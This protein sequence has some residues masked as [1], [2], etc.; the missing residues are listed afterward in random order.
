MTTT[1]PTAIGLPVSDADPFSHEVLEDP[2]P[3]HAQLRD[4]G[5]VVYLDRYD[6]YAFGRHEQVHAALVD[7]QQFQSAAGVGLSNFRYEKPWRPP[8]LV[9][10]A[11]PPRHDAPRRVLTKVLGPRAL[12]RL[13]EQWVADAEVLV[14]QVLAAGAE[15][16]AVPALAEAF[17][18]RV[19]PDAV[20]LPAQGRENLLP[21]GDHAFNAFGPPNDLV[22]RGNP[23][24][25]ELSAWVGAQ[26][27][28]EVLAPQGFGADIWAAADR[29][30]IT[31][32]QAPL[33]VRS[34]LTAGVDTTVHGLSAVLYAVATNPDQ[35]RR[36][37]AQPELAR[38]AFDEAVR[39]E[40]PVQTFFRTAT[41]DVAVAGHVVPEGKK[42]LMFL[43]SANRDPRRWA[44]P[45]AFDLGRDPSGHVGFG[46]GIHQCVGQHV[47]RLEAEA[48]LTAL[49]RRVATIEPAG[50]TKRHHNNTLR[51]WE[52]IPVRML[53]A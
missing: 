51:A 36:L 26:C 23:R 48:L 14:D 34:L 25:A 39:W 18:L 28:R 9:L 37:R 19:F 8:S 24:V 33:V 38:V 46:M 41:T 31:H 1:A 35:W 50:P 6:V 11:D 53:P 52:S 21:Y 29:G 20:G 30:D 7:W 45:D 47:A 5:P 49:A 40:S 10:E 2:T 27:A 32:E 17:P 42:I 13:H 43:A 15:F 3:F 22:A 4:A 12:R 44:D 16:D